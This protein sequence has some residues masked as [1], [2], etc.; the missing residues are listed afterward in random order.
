MIVFSIFSIRP[1]WNWFSRA[2]CTRSSAS[3]ASASPGCSHEDLLYIHSVLNLWL[4]K[5]TYT[6]GCLLNMSFHLIN[7]MRIEKNTELWNVTYWFRL[8]ELPYSK[9]IEYFSLHSDQL[10]LEIF[11]SNR[12]IS[13]ML[14][15]DCFSKQNVCSSDVWRRWSFTIKTTL[16]MQTRF[17]YFYDKYFLDLESM[18]L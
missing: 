15:S 9:F 10:S 12:W 4:K 11:S 13:R 7:K 5:G 18:S 16:C 2:L 8:K 1:F 6:S 14:Y 17:W 3:L